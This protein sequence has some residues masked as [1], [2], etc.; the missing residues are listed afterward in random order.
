MFNKIDIFILRSWLDGDRVKGKSVL[1]MFGGL[2]MILFSNEEK[3]KEVRSLG[4]G[5][6]LRNRLGRSVMDVVKVKSLLSVR[7]EF[8]FV[9][10]ELMII[11]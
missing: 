2:S 5:G 6:S 10:F 1:N 4:S 11:E 3:V 9:S 7:R 8:G